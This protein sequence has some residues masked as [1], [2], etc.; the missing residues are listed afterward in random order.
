MNLLSASYLLSMTHDCPVL[1][2][3]AIAVEGNL[4]KDIGTK[5]ELQERYP[6]AKS[7]HFENHV[8][9]PGLVNAHCQ[10]DL[11]GFYESILGNKD[12]FEP[13]QYVETLIASMHYRNKL[14][15]QE[16]MDLAKT[17]LSRLANTGTTTLG[18]MTCKEAS[19]KLLADSKLRVMAYPEIVL[20]QGEKAQENFEIAM[21]LAER[22]S[23]MHLSRMKTGV[24]PYAP[25]LLSRNTLRMLSLFC[26]NMKLPLQIHAAEAFAEMEFFFDSEGPM[27][28]L[29]QHMGWQQPSPQHKT[30]IQ[31]LADIGF[32]DAPV[33]IVGCLHLSEKDLPLMARHLTQVV[34]SPITNA[35]MGHGTLPLAKL[36]DAGIPIGLGSQLWNGKSGLCLWTEMR[37]ALRQGSDPLPSAAELLRM[38]TIGGARVLGLEQECGTLEMGKQAD[39]I[40]VKLHENCS[41]KNLSERIVQDT[42]DSDISYVSVAGDV[43]K[44]IGDTC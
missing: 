29:F 44:H 38:A 26:R 40:A 33:C 14:D 23:E 11:I 39:I 37:E 18:A 35:V 16:A 19:L 13:Q 22:Y 20:G 30:P 28:K 5:E 2:H 36:R 15:V 6:T 10:L 4:I 12:L 3:G 21:A 31:Y 17:A 32:L 34:Y 24:G 7:L 27:L 9:M 41:E 42:E 8:L 1:A 25:Y 43:L